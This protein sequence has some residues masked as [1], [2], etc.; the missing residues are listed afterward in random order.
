MCSDLPAS[1]P[2]LDMGGGV[3]GQ[4][5]HLADLMSGNI[6]A[7]DSYAPAIG[8]LAR[9]VAERGLADRVQP[10]VGDMAQPDFSPESFD[11]V[12]SEGALYFIGIE[13]ALVDCRSLLRS[14]GYLAFTNAVWRKENPPAQVQASLDDDCPA[15]GTADDLLVTIERSGFDLVGHF[16]LPDEVWWDDFYTPMRARINELRDTYGTDAEALALLDQI[17]RETEM[18]EEY[19]EYYAYGFF[20][21]RRR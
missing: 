6:V 20:V 15:M 13:K 8:R 11:L 10:V 5:L 9:T 16:A 18:H 19:S 21:A 3:G 14:G 2:V 4:T 12:W 17:W 7:I 1:G